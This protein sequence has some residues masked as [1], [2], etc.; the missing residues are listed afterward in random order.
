MNTMELNVAMMRKGATAQT[1]SEAIKKSHVSFNKKRCGDV[2][3]DVN[4]VKAIA[5]ALDLDLQAVNLI[6]FDLTLHDGKGNAEM[7]P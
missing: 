5:S 4:E 3:F 6:F 7:T 1:M 2:P